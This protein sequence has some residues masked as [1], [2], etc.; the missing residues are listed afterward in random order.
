[1]A[2]LSVA[3]RRLILFAETDEVR[4]LVA[5]AVDHAIRDER[6]DPLILGTV[7][8]GPAVDHP[9]SHVAE[10]LG[11]A[12]GSRGIVFRRPSSFR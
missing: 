10:T 7:N 1:M 3:E 5:S 6:L 4:K 12:S 2:W 8:D 9:I 11:H